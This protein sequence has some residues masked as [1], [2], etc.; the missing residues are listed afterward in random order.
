MRE[1]DYSLDGCYFVTI[2]TRDR[3]HYLG[4]VENRQVRLSAAGEILQTCW[5]EIPRHFPFARLD[6]FIIMPNHLHGIV[7]V[8]RSVN[9]NVGGADLRPVKRRPPYKFWRPDQPLADEDRSKMVL[10][11]I[12]HGVKSTVIRIINKMD[13]RED[14]YCA[15]QRSFYDHIIRDETSLQGIRE[16][17]CSN[18]WNW[19]EDVE[20]PLY[21]AALPEKRRQQEAMDHYRKIF[22]EN[23]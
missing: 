10:C 4:E 6:E 3:Q 9:A 21:L 19:D 14:V 16:Y 5:L 20:N 7:S 18:P 13:V 2:C 17:I 23:R 8:G 1:R 12:I 11:K 15:W 22:F